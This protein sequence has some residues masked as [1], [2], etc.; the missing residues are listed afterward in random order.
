MYIFGLEVYSIIF[1]LMS[2][3]R[4]GKS[5]ELGANST[6]PHFYRNVSYLTASD[7]HNH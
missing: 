3:L 2:P 4:R 1:S 5:W 7:E 6:F